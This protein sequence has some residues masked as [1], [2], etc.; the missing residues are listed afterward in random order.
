[1]KKDHIC[2]SETTPVC[3]AYLAYVST[4][5]SLHVPVEKQVTTTTVGGEFQK[6]TPHQKLQLSFVLAGRS[7]IDFRLSLLRHINADRIFFRKKIL[8]DDEKTCL[9]RMVV[10]R[11]VAL[12]LYCH[13]IC[14][15][16]NLSRFQLNLNSFTFALN[17]RMIIAQFHVY[18]SSFPLVLNGR[19]LWFLFLRVFDGLLLVEKCLRVRCADFFFSQPQH[20]LFHMTVECVVLA[21][22][23]PVCCNETSLNNRPAN[24]APSKSQLRFYHILLI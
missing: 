18:S 6:E 9:P 12:F 5:R 20:I 15:P 3:W 1:M 2:P 11:F 8:L 13:L 16:N 14:K 23:G 7:E 21:I 24:V 22:I 10:L 17:E 19:L 4:L